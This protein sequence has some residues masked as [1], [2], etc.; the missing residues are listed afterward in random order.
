MNKVICDNGLINNP[1]NLFNWV[2]IN[3]VPYTKLQM[4]L[5]AGGCLMW[6]VAY[7]IM[8]KNARKFRFIEMAA[9]AGV[10]NFAWEALWSWWYTPDTGQ[11][12]VWTYRAW[13]FLDVYIVYL[14]FKYGHKQIQNEYLRKYYSL[15]CP[16][17]L[18]ACMVVYY[19]FIKQGYDMPIGANTAYICQII[20]SVLCPL[21]LLNAKTLDG[22]SFHFAWLR[23]FGTAANTVFMFLHY[24]DNHFVHTL[25]VISFVLDMGY[26]YLYKKKELNLKQGYTAAVA[27]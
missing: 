5:F 27:A 4:V 19:Y 8:I 7:V 16:A 15:W 22:I 6:V 10:S 24:P 23:T 11:F 9:F 25:G 1:D 18:V 13:F 14:L 20:L 26:L 21:V 12:M 2:D 17:A 3:C